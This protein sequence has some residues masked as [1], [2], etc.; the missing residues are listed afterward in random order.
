MKY[1]IIIV[2]LVAAVLVFQ[3]FAN[4]KNIE[5]KNVIKSKI[6]SGALIV[7]VRTPME[8]SAGHYPRAINIPVDQIGARSSELGSKDR[9]IILYCQSGNRSGHAKRILESQ[10]FKNVYNA[11]VLRDMP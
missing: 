9:N 7:D 3:N 8:F 6:D 10:G 11:G 2:V 1:L 5:N 4:S